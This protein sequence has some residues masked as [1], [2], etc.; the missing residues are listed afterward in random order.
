M[1]QSHDA[2]AVR[3]A[4]RL[5][6]E[7]SRA[8]LLMPGVLDEAW[9]SMML[10]MRVASSGVVAAMAACGLPDRAKRKKP[11]GVG[12]AAC[13]PC[14][15]PNRALSCWDL[16]GLL[17]LAMRAST[18]FETMTA[19]RTCNPGHCRQNEKTKYARNL[20]NVC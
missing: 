7:A 5:L 11:V 9:V 18:G 17:G 16:I 4:L 6:G 10:P 12:D 14:Q 13:P 20:D 1:A 2:A 19:D 15:T 8:D 3:E